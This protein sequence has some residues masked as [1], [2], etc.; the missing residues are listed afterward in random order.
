MVARALQFTQSKCTSVIEYMYKRFQLHIKHHSVSWLPNSELKESPMYSIE[1]LRFRLEEKGQVS[2]CSHKLTFENATIFIHLSFKRKENEIT[3]I[4]KKIRTE[5]FQITK[6][7]IL[8]FYLAIKTRHT[9]ETQVKQR[10]K[11]VL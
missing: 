2:S 8:Y 1:N 11:K 5:Q 9:N 7:H 6:Y 10:D 3:F 4:F